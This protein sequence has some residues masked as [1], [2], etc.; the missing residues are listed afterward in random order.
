MRKSITLLLLL[1]AT[2]PSARA[3]G[4][5]NDRETVAT[6]NEFRSRYESPAN[7]AMAD[8][9]STTPADPSVL[10]SFSEWNYPIAATGVVGITLVILAWH[11]SGRIPKPPI[12][13]GKSMFGTPLQGRGPEKGISTLFIDCLQLGRRI[14]VLI[15]ISGALPVNRPPGANQR[16][17]FT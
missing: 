17:V 3:F 6:E 7:P 12:A 13:E 1:I 9:G 14:N 2:L 11:I 5:L 15:P 4:C 10:P 16:Q 8:G